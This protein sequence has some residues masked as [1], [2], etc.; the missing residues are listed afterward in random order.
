MGK[1][2]EISYDEYENPIFHMETISGELV[3]WHNCDFL[4]ISTMIP[5]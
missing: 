3:K 2:I 5:M 4:K 1:I